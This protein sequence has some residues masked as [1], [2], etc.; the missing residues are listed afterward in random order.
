MIIGTFWSQKDNKWVRFVEEDGLVRAESASAREDNPS[1]AGEWSPEGE[2]IWSVNYSLGEEAPLRNEF[3]RVQDGILYHDT[4]ITRYG[5]KIIEHYLPSGWG[6]YPESMKAKYNPFSNVQGEAVELLAYEQLPL[7]VEIQE[8][9]REEEERLA[10][11]ARELERKQWDGIIKSDFFSRFVDS[12]ESAF[13]PEQNA[14]LYHEL[15]KELL[16]FPIRHHETPADFVGLWSWA[17]EDR[18]SDIYRAVIKVASTTFLDEDFNLNPE[19]DEET[20]RWLFEHKKAFCLAVINAGVGFV[21]DTFSLSNPLEQQLA[22]LQVPLNVEA[23]VLDTRIK[24][25]IGQAIYQFFSGWLATIAQFIPTIFSWSKPA[26]REDV[27]RED[28]ARED[29]PEQHEQAVVIARSMQE[30]PNLGAASSQ[31]SWLSRKKAGELVQSSMSYVS[32]LGS[33]FW[34]TPRP[35]DNA[36]RHAPQPDGEESQF[37]QRLS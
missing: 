28:V 11:E 9:R 20:R 23:P 31:E 4:G 30:G 8:E 33:L 18:E 17:L 14:Y 32:S 15:S 19:K 37:E 36:Q 26:M 29:G 34:S 25:N 7:T 6:R 24:V 5:V 21:C 35:T 12:V 16:S 1:L 13:T 10:E 2:G 22:A 3:Y 27:A